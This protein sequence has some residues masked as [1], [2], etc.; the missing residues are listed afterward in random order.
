MKK[1]FTLF[2]IAL[3]FLFLG[4]SS[5]YGQLSGNIY[6]PSGSP[7][8][9]TI[10]AA[11]AALNSQGVGTGGVTF[12]IVADYTEN[13]TDSLIIT[14]TGTA[15]RPIVFQKDPETVGANPLV[16]R[17][18]AGIHATTTIGARGD[19]II[20]IEGSD[21]V[22]FDGIDVT[23]SNQGI[24]YGYYIRKASA[25]N[26]CKYVTIKNSVITMCKGTSAYVVGLYSSNNIAGSALNSASG[27]TVTSEGGRHEYVTIIGNTVQ[28][29][30]YGMYF[31]G[32]NHTT[33]PYNYYDQ[34][35]TI[36]AEGAGNII[37]NFGG[38]AAS[39]SDGIIITYHNNE[40]ISYNTINNTDGGGTGF[41]SYGNG[42]LLNTGK[43]VTLNVSYN[44]ISL[45]TI[46]GAKYLY[47]IQ[48]NSGDA[49]SSITINN[50]IFQNCVNNST[51][52]LTAI[53]HG[54]A[55]AISIYFNTI[56]NFTSAT[57]M[58][59]I[60]QSAG[61]LNNFIY[62]NKISDIT[63]TGATATTYIYGITLAKGTNTVYNNLIYNLNA[64]ASLCVDAL[65]GINITSTAALT[66][67][68]VYY[69]TIY[70]NAASSGTDFGSTCV[71]HTYSATSTSVA[72]DMRNNILVNTSIPNGAGKTV[73]FRRS[74]ATDLNNYSTLSNYNL[75]YAGTPDASR[76]LY[77]DGT[78]FDQ[79]LADYQT[80][81]SPMD[82]N[83]VSGD[84][85]FTS[86]V[87]LKPNA[88]NPNSWNV[89]GGAYP[90]PTVTTDFAGATRRTA[91]TEGPEDIGA[92]KF[93]AP[94]AGQ[95]LVVTGSISDGSTSTIT[96]AGKTL[97]SIT[98]HSGTGSLPSSIS[99]IYKPGV[100]PIG[101]LAQTYAYEY[102]DID[103]TGGT[104]PYTYDLTLYYNLARTY[105][106]NVSN[107][108]NIRATKCSDTTW[109]PLLTNTTTNTIN[110]SVTITG[111]DNGFS[112]FT[113]TGGDSPLPVELAS[114]TSNVSGRNVKLSWSTSKEINNSGF[115]IQRTEKS[116][117][118]TW[119][120]VGYV[121]GNGNT[122]NI[123]N[124][125]FEDKTLS[126]GKFNYR[127]KQIDN[128][129]NFRYHKLNNVVEVAV[130]IRYDLSQNYP[131]PFNPVTKIDFQLPFDSR[132]RIV[133]YDML[134]RE[135]KTLVS[136]ELKLAGFH[137][138]ELNATN[139]A[140]GMYF[141]RMIANAQGKDN[142]FTKKMVLIK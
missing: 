47:C 35:F 20:I 51:G 13:V 127:L 7:S 72:L 112:Y 49:S 14:A 55:A 38:N 62:N 26:G 31:L 95:N 132:V 70:L 18:N 77:Y 123:T 109:S 56:T 33:S 74:A 68:G 4:N 139:L 122:N 28:N 40:S 137:T 87:D 140:S 3:C 121:K 12:N 67:E 111:I 88:S 101:N 71:Y 99:A 113:F 60:N 83:S 80:R 141:Y 78:N 32:Y 134:G 131:N 103:A 105:N 53:Q 19:A 41:T 8:Y 30:F 43:A 120:N 108:S 50:N 93:S 114:F 94:S 65:R 119:L 34:N 27:V 22:T 36:G 23:A 118:E 11:I 75:F 125:N 9:A 115:E 61:T 64:P 57:S 130:P 44:T 104:L 17:T 48:V 46:S 25:T 59:L 128:N 110:K 106:I 69:N 1:L 16:T 86:N 116:S 81:V 142:I 138:V 82:D 6:I 10:A 92:Y 136:G 79:T 129:G 84:P 126:T 63:T 133:V 76:V 135:I 54:T 5:S 102:L 85:G 91:I 24:E 73:T 2:G 21:Y 39:T 37:Q 117:S 52:M 90:I 66:T 100:L 15:D 107:Q 42:I 124:Y 45:T 96:F 29:V 89:K 97:A 58:V 98:W